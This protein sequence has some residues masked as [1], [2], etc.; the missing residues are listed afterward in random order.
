MARFLDGRLPDVPQA[1]RCAAGSIKDVS[2]TSHLIEPPKCR[3]RLKF[4]W[5]SQAVVRTV[6]LLRRNARRQMR[7][8][9]WSRLITWQLVALRLGDR[10][11]HREI[12]VH[13]NRPH[14]QP[15]NKLP[16]SNFAILGDAGLLSC[17]PQPSWQLQHSRR[18]QYVANLFPNVLVLRGTEFHVTPREP[19]HKVKG[20]H[21]HA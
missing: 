20:F 17:P 18:C 4:S 2:G 13:R 19:C 14:H 10:D 16:G 15:R 3:K 12:K 1:S 11:C 9:I 21:F 6:V 5:V 8:A 7:L